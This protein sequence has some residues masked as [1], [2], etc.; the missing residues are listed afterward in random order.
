MNFFKNKLIKRFRF[1]NL[2]TLFGLFV[3]QTVYSQTSGD[4]IQYSSMYLQPFNR[5]AVKVPFSTSDPGTPT[6]IHWGMDTAWDDEGN[7]LRGINFIGLDRLTYGRISFQVMDP[8]KEDGS[9]S[10]RQINYLKSRL[11]HISLSK[12]E[13]VLLNSDPVDINVDVYT[14]HPEEWYKVIKATLKYV[15]D[16]GLK[17]VSIAPF[18][19]PDVTASNQGTKADFRSVARLIKEDPFFD[20]IRICAGNTCNNDGAM[21]WYDYMKPYVDEGNTHQLAGD[22]NHYSDFYKH[23]KS[24]GNVATN[25]ELHNVMEGIVGANYGM[26]NGIWWGTVGPSRGDF[27]VATSAGGSRLGYGENRSAWS[28]SAVYRMPD[29]SIKTFAGMSER[30][31]SSCSYEYVC[32]DKP[33]FF[34]GYGPVYS[35]SIS[36]PGGYR[37]GDQY[38]KSAERSVRVSCGEDVPLYPLTNSNYIIV[39]KKSQKLLTIQGGST[40]NSASVVLYDNKGYT[41]QQWSLEQLKDNAGD[42]TGF[43]VHSVRKGGMNMET[44]GFQVR[45][46]G[47]VSVYPITNLENQ[48]WTFE[49]AGDGYYKIRNYQSGLYLEANGART[50]N[51]TTVTLCS[52]ATGDHQLWKFLPVDA[53][54]ETVAP[55][56]PSNVTATPYVNSVLLSWDANVQDKDFNGYIV[57]RGEKNGE[58]EIVYDVIGRGVNES[59]FLD[60]T[61]HANHTYY[62]S[63]QSVD[64]SQ[65]RSALSEPI[66]VSVDYKKGLIARYEFELSPNDMTD[67]HLNAVFSVPTIQTSETSNVR[68]GKSS[69]LFDGVSN[70]INLPST[71][72]NLPNATFALWVYSPSD[73]FAK[74]SRLYDFVSDANHYASLSLNSGGKIEYHIVNGE[75]EQT[76]QAGSL[77]EGW[78]HVALSIGFE[79]VTIY[80]DGTSVSSAPVSVRLTDICPVLNSVGASVFEDVPLMDGCIDDLRIYN[81]ELSANEINDIIAQTHSE[82]HQPEGWIPPSLPCKNVQQLTSSES[83]LMY[84]VEADAFV[85]YGMSWNTQSLAQRLPKGD[86]TIANKYRLKV[87][88]QTG[89][90]LCLSMSDKANSYIGC[91]SDACNVWSDRT[92]TEG[93]FIY[94]PVSTPS[95]VVYTLK[96]VSQVALLDVTYAYGGPLTTSNGRGYTQWAFI[97]PRDITNGNYAKYKERSRLYKLQQSILDAKKGSDYSSELQHAYSVYSNDDATVSE[98]RDATRQLLIATAGDITCSVDATCLF[99]NADMLGN[100]TTS[101][102]TDTNTTITDGDIEVLHQPI[103]LQQTQTDLP[104]GIYDV[105][106]HGFYRNDATGQLP[107]VSASA[108][109][110][111]KDNLPTLKTVSETEV[112]LTTD[113]TTSGAAQT[114]TSDRSQT[115]LSDIYVVDHK[116]TLSANVTSSNQWVNFQGFSITYKNPLLTVQVPESGYTTFYYSNQSFLLPEGMQAFTLKERNNSIV[117]S[118]RI[119]TS[120]AVLPAGQAVLLKAEPGTYVMFPTTSKPT[121]DANNQLRGTDED[122]LTHGGNYYYTLDNSNQQVGLKWM[123]T[124]G[125]TFVNPA[126]HAYFVSKSTTAPQ[127]YFAVDVITSIPDVSIDSYSDDEAKY[128]LS[129]QRVDDS[130]RSIIITKGRKI[131]VK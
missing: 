103:K 10:D 22:F 118:R 117:V 7:V 107:V 101:D 47:T 102:W 8:V 123:S 35:Y 66:S 94:N 1:L 36:L 70:Y 46:G 93:S 95:G 26:E 120:G 59:R 33:V 74:N 108:G 34:D 105:V 128:N 76:L 72:S 52:E 67:N 81:Y 104:N 75:S 28:G 97:S 68:S 92:K 40:A 13:G 77:S 32:R 19:E 106:F 6:P 4:N 60:N 111:V 2:L 5:H 96:S 18:N 53:V 79:Q 82:P 20:G 62:Y 64:Y 41:Y 44:G 51:N 65:N 12:P 54:C 48:R 126:H 122:Q 61:C 43:Y 45:V 112:L 3:C 39:N 31:A 115:T 21:E 87:Q 58:G 17:V 49:Y 119:V 30:Q 85:T 50:T 23:V 124:D 114:L 127:E 42:L 83:V 78:H 121:I 37:Y 100:G 129:G 38:Q 99:T 116:M 130:Y 63:I 91:L 24:D 14:H 88:R 109:N 73:S 57:L 71:V 98:L 125:S 15:Q 55:Q 25:D 27:C 16:Y 86:T 113:E 9:L 90:K 29:G 80:V 69:F 56:V 110:T 84:N 89:N 11:R 131:L